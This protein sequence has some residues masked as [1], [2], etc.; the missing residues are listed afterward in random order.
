[1]SRP[2][3]PSVSGAHFISIGQQLV[4]P[5]ICTSEKAKS[6]RVGKQIMMRFH[7]P[8]ATAP[9]QPVPKP[10]TGSSVVVRQVY[11]VRHQTQRP[12]TAARDKK[13]GRMESGSFREAPCFC[14]PT[15]DPKIELP[16]NGNLVTQILS[17]RHC[18]SCCQSGR[19]RHHAC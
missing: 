10:G 6:P 8:D 14:M 12:V 1:M 16:S 7:R 15:K 19:N 3:G 13:D 4:S 11:R 18:R 17:K 5:S 2:L 9:G